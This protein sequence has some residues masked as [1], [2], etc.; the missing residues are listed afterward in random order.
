MSNIVSEEIQSNG[1]SACIS[2]RGEKARGRRRRKEE[3]KAEGVKISQLCL[4]R[5]MAWRHQKS[6]GLLP[7]SSWRRSSLVAWQ[8]CQPVKEKQKSISISVWHMRTVYICMSS[9]N[10]EENSSIIWK[11]QRKAQKNQK[12]K[13]KTT[14]K[15]KWKAS[16]LSLYISWRKAASLKRRKYREKH[17]G[18]KIHQCKK[19]RRRGGGT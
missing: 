9:N 16:F 18:G 10:E 3:K 17:D 2:W 4:I 11:R 6:G 12:K 14:K 13:K 15:R 19:A 5:D 1:L 7:Q 8:I